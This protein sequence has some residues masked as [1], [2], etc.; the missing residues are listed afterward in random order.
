ML[1]ETLQKVAN[2]SDT[3]IMQDKETQL[4]H[5][6]NFVVNEVMPKVAPYGYVERSL[7]HYEERYNIQHGNFSDSKL[8]ETEQLALLGADYALSQ[9]LNPLPVIL[10]CVI[11]DLTEKYVEQ[12]K[13]INDKRIPKTQEDFIQD[14]KNF[15]E[16]N[17][18]N[19]TD[20][21]KE[22][23]INAVFFPEKSENA[24]IIACINKAFQTRASWKNE[25]TPEKEVYLKQQL[26]RL[27][28]TDMPSYIQQQIVYD[29]TYENSPIVGTKEEPIV[30]YHSTPENIAKLEPTYS[31]MY[32][33]KKLYI[34]PDIRYT[35]THVR[36]NK[37]HSHKKSN[38]T[39]ISV[40]NSAGIERIF[41]MN[42]LRTQKHMNGKEI[43][44]HLN[45]NTTRSQNRE[46]DT[47]AFVY[48]GELIGL[49]PERDKSFKKQG[50]DLPME[51]ICRFM[52]IDYPI[53]DNKKF[54]KQTIKAMN[55]FEKIREA[56]I[57]LRR[58]A[59]DLEKLKNFLKYVDISDGKSNL[60]ES[61][62]APYVQMAKSMLKA[63]IESQSPQDLTFQIR[64]GLN[65]NIAN[66]I[67]GLKETGFCM[68]YNNPP[69]YVIYNPNAV[70]VTTRYQMDG[71]NIAK[72]EKANAEGHFG[73]MKSPQMVSQL[74]ESPQVPQQ[75]VAELPSSEKVAQSP[76]TPN[77][78]AT[79]EPPKVPERPKLSP[80]QLAKNIH[81]YM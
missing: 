35:L 52:E 63:F 53:Q 19:L 31:T 48:K 13:Y 38:K 32:D 10:G 36:G 76:I 67:D 64:H 34:S 28:K 1:K 29:Y 12:N 49:F 30:F 41:Y 71:Y 5:W 39:L 56:D 57:H 59:Q 81:R 46:I 26:N 40:N 60:Q 42:Y 23:I 61:S 45:E 58:Y 65:K 15:L 70:R 77:K 51:H 66:L 7:Y 43:E 16:Q 27:N 22:Q 11:K 4:Q 17:Q 8:A 47:P 69:H 14:S 25:N 9:G 80:E 6:T 68:N 18:L 21:D 33:E 54:L 50:I 37:D 24:D 73:A 78:S 74:V 55:E 2:A 44:Q 3:P 75:M 62:R 79:V 20:K 72:V